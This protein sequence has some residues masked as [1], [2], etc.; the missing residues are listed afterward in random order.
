[1]LSR[2]RT[3]GRKSDKL[4]ELLY[5]PRCGGC[6]RRGELFCTRCKAAIVTPSA[7][8]I[9]VPGIDEVFCVGMFAGPL[10]E[11]V[12]KFKYESD[13]PLAMVLGEL[14]EDTLSD[15]NLPKRLRE[16]PP[17]L[18][19][20]PLH[21]RRERQRGYNQCALLSEV[22]AGKTGWETRRDL[23]RVKITRAQV[24]LSGKER[25]LNVEDAFAWNSATVPPHV[26]LVDDVCTTGA[27]L[28]ECAAAI[29]K[30]GGVRVYAAVVARATISGPHS[31]R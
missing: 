7:G 31:D 12:H 9:I 8:T 19:P 20:V 29:K 15:E 4:L 21:Y 17:T 27:T 28:A 10:R 5:P 16:V 6:D 3:A 13:T 11:A 24:G 14:M 18:V 1:M 26:M 30:A 2:L 23:V 25:T 22:I